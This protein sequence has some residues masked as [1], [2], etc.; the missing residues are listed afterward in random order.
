MRFGKPRKLLL[1]RLFGLKLKRVSKLRMDPMQPALSILLLGPHFCSH[2]GA[3]CKS[4]AGKHEESKASDS[5]KS[6]ARN[7][8]D[9]KAS[10]REEH[11]AGDREENKAG[12]RA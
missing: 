2:C 8:E 10:N 1:G 3:G 12:N 6:D 9:S 5:E 7:S 11:N 4:K